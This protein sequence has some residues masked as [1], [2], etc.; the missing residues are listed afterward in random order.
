ME[1]T[2]HVDACTGAL[3]AYYKSAKTKDAQ[4]IVAAVD[5]LKET[6][7]HIMRSSPDWKKIFETAQHLVKA[8]CPDL[9]LKLVDKALIADSFKTADKTKLIEIGTGILQQDVQW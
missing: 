1:W 8:S 6:G 2:I 7:V 5:H 4:K 3:E 9:S